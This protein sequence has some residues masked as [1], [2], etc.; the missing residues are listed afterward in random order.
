MTKFSLGIT[1][2]CKT[3]EREAVN[4]FL[5]DNDLGPDNVNIQTKANEWTTWM[6]WHED[7]LPLLQQLADTMPKIDIE[8]AGRQVAGKFKLD[9]ILAK[10][11]S[12]FNRSE[13]QN[14]NANNRQKAK[15]TIK[16]ETDKK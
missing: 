3:S 15:V 11:N 8:I 13:Y 7:N 5:E 16:A 4:T 14:P 1:V 6:P 9:K 10:I 12:V 2:N